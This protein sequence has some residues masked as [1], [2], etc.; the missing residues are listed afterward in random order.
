M[1]IHPHGIFSGCVLFAV[2][3]ATGLSPASAD[4]LDSIRYNE[5]ARTYAAGSIQKFTP[6]DGAV[7]VVT[8]DNQTV[9][10]RMRLGMHDVFYLK[11]KNPAEVAVG[12]LYTV[13]QRSRKVYHPATGQYLGYLITR[14]AIVQVVQIDGELTTA[15]ALRSFGPASP[16]DPVARFVPPTANAPVGEPASGEITGMV[17]ELQADINMS[18]V[19]QRNIV[20]LD[21]GSEDG[22]RVGDR[23][24]LV[25]YG[26][27]LPP[28][29]VGEVKVLST[30]SRTSTALVTKSTSRILAGDQFRAKYEPDVVP[31]A[32][33]TITPSPSMKEPSTQPS[34][35]PSIDKRT[36]QD[37]SREVRYTLN[38]LMKQLHYESGEATIKPEGYQTLDQLVEL[39]KAAPSEQLIRVEGH[40]DNMEI[41]P[42]LKSRYATNWDLSKA[43]AS[44]VLRYLV[45]KGGIDSARV[46]SI[47]YGATKPLTSNATEA[48]RS[49]NR[50]VEVVLYSSNAAPADPE[51]PTVPAEAAA[52]DGYHMSGLRSTPPEPATSSVDKAVAPP[53]ENA[54]KPVPAPPVASDSTAA[55]RQA[56]PAR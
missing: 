45:E 41:G 40:A 34:A 49:K 29:M 55:D 1:T 27:G 22:L 28:R 8:G 19:A 6:Q 54:D 37:A 17:I 56:V 35:D 18:L 33:P 51:P 39:V 47:G 20:Y 44:G 12:D 9:G 30:E 4:D 32:P 3:A 36:V 23:M 50:R 15:R 2:I 42:A 16:G 26:G 24:E 43:R 31:A 21:R 14:L 25:R 13:Y 48:G 5:A 53:V 46:S 10:N 7:N 52:D 11:M 38:D